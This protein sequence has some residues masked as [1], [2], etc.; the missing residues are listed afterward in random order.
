MELLQLILVAALGLV[1]VA[2]ILRNRQAS[3]KA[4]VQQLAPAASRKRRP[5]GT[6]TREE[7]AKHASRDDLWVI[8]KDKRSQEW[9]VF[10]LTDY[11]DE[12][13]GGDAILTNAGSDATE[14]FHGP[15]H[16]ESVFELVKDYC[17]GTL[18]DP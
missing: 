4:H 10:E 1:A 6:W 16:P 14:G 17:I 2:F 5:Q 18:A 15:Q 13:P 7:V 3:Y 12:H 11:V 8:I 9:K